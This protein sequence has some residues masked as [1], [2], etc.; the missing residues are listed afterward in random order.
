[1]FKLRDY[2]KVQK[3]FIESRID[4]ANVIGIESG[5]GSG[6]TITA[7][8]F[9][10]EWLEKPENQLTNVVIT[11][12][13]NNLVFL[14]EKRALE[15]GFPREKVKILIGTGACNCPLEMQ[16]KG[17]SDK[18]TEYMV[19]TETDEYRCGDKH[20][21]FDVSTDVWAKKI[22]PFTQNLYR[23]YFQ[24][25]K[26][27]VGQI[28]ITNHSSL[29]IHQ[30]NLS[31]T[32][33]LIIDE[34]HTFSNFYESYL[35]LE[36]DKSDLTSID[37]AINNLK[38]PMNM[39]IKMNM[40][41]GVQLPNKQIDAI[42]D[43]IE[44]TNLSLRTREFFETKPDISNYIERTQNSYTI[45]RFYRSF[46]L[47]IV[48][49]P[50]IILFSATLDDFTLNM[51]NVH[52]SNIYREY[53]TFC[54]YSKS[55]L[56]CIPNDD[57]ETSLLKFLD[58]VNN[59]G[60]SRGLILSTTITDMNKALSYDGIHGYKMFEDL[61][62]F[63]KADNI[64]TPKKILVGSRG[65]F[66]GIDIN[67][68]QF[69]CLNKL[70]FPVYDDKSRAQQNYLTN[71]GQN[72]FDTWNS[73]VVPKVEN[74]IIQSTGRLWRNTSSHGVISI[75]D[76]RVEKFRYIMRKCF[77]YHRHGIESNIMREDGTIEEFK[78]KKE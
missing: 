19:F 9:V 72:D 59:K 62:K 5:T 53:K 68:L 46:D 56:I 7:L 35:R 77:D 69:V 12:G 45:D 54:D 11:T 48:S 8:Q 33:L 51:F 36:L 58:Y 10:K 1:M 29:L 64:S 78:L 60:L 21:E 65:L 44:N 25:I 43:N 63:E 57:F 22:C 41:K 74:D 24:T 61:N 30:E 15:M 73:F 75:F 47:N 20:K 39:I 13:F 4:I 40:Q 71:N 28:I 50:K 23:E 52:K 38:P 76:S 34:A 37:K 16:E 6:K 18:D 42:C 31:N 26:N 70:P 49:K 27:N 32:S 3:E 66:Q 14:M 67:D 17:V 55:E 2:Q